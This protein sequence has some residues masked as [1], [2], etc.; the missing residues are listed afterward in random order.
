MSGAGA[1]VGTKTPEEPLPCLSF[2]SSLDQAVLIR[3]T[4]CTY[5]DPGSLS[6]LKEIGCKMGWP[7]HISPPFITNGTS[8][9]LKLVQW[10][11]QGFRRKAKTRKIR[12]RP[13]QFSLRFFKPDRLL[14]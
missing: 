5:T 11:K 3:T 13:A 7:V 6:D 2:F 14:V 10:G 8:I 9:G 1:P 12:P 4:P